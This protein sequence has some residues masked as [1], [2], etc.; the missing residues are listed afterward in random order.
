MK[1]E[2]ESDWREQ[3]EDQIRRKESELEDLEWEVKLSKPG[4]ELKAAYRRQSALDLLVGV[5]L[6]PIFERLF[7]V[8]PTYMESG[9]TAFYVRFVQA[10][11]R[12]SGITK[13]GGKPYAAGTIVKALTDANGR[14]GGKK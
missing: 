12:R 3:L 6:P 7:G 4:T 14:T 1:Q 9:R 13:K 2:G 11:L 5:L 8:K 10:V